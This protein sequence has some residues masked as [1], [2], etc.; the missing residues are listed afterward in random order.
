MNAVAVV[1]GGT[2][3]IG[4]AIVE[5]LARTGSRVEFCARKRNDVDRHQEQWRAAGF[6][7]T[8]TVCDVTDE[9]TVDRYVRNIV[10]RNGG[11]DHLINNAG[12]SGG[13]PFDSLPTEVW[14]R[15]MATNCDSVFFMSRAILRDGGILDSDHGRIVNISST[16]GKQG[17]PLAAPYNASK[18]AVIG[19]TRSLALEYA[20]RGVTVNAICPGYVQTPMADTVVRRHA[21]IADRDFED[22]RSDFESKIPIG[23]YTT[24]AEVASFVEYLVRPEAA[25]ITGQAMNVCG[26]LGRF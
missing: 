2:S 23:R 19:I 15:I 11:I 1:T 9:G 3:G 14:H 12:T 10:S 22:V 16:A 20:K 25:A 6:D 21:E 17:I 7:V 13:G 24:A 8:G 18:H 5:A 4:E 26:G